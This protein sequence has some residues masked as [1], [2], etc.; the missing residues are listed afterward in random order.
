MDC[1]AVKRG[2]VPDVYDPEEEQEESSQA[3]RHKK[4]PFALLFFPSCFN[5]HLL[6]SFEPKQPRLTPSSRTPRGRST[7]DGF[8]LLQRR[9][10]CHT[11]LCLTIFLQFFP[12]KDPKKLKLWLQKLLDNE[13]DDIE[14]LA[15]QTLDTLVKLVGIP[16]AIAGK[17]A[18]QAALC[19][20]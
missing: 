12:G 11:C 17:L 14:T 5:S 3:K 20:G 19:S 1:T 6:H 9:Y 7:W 13:V 15:K 10:T 18:E 2:R 8:R 4:G 16:A